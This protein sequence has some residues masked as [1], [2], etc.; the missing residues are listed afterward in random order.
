MSDR[1][2]GDSFRRLI[3]LT[4]PI[5]IQHYMGES[6]ARYY[7]GKDPLGSAGDFVTAPEISQMFGELIGLWLVDIWTRAG[8]PKPVHYVELG[9][10]RGTLAK[11]ALR[12]MRQYG[13]TPEVHFVEGS[14][15][16]RSEQS[17]AVPGAHF[18]DDLS[19]LPDDAPLL[20]VGNEFLDALP[21]RQ[22]VKTAEG[23]RER[24]VAVEGEKFVCVAGPNPMDAAIPVER[25]DAPDGAIIETCP[26]AAAVVG[27]VS[28]RLAAQGGAA[29][30]ID[31]G[32]DQVQTGST[33]QAVR[34]HQKVDPFA[35][36]G[37]ADLTALV[38]F[39][40]LAEMIAP[41]GSRY[42]G[43]VTQGA[44]LKALGIE[45]RAQALAQKSPAHSEAL[46]VA[47]DRLVDDAQMGRL[48]KVMGLA[49]PN[50][51]NGAA[52]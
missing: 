21:I 41:K 22:L 47:K 50:W 24:M 34:A 20:I 35:A 11:D 27:E 37:E 30:L 46:Q 3:S 16:L 48:F 29:L 33:L 40:T 31:Y 23:W 38:D 10:G 15:V 2:L 25:R 5:S 52:F 8:Q 42:L 13:L 12:A 9:P 28:Q 18:H 49:A 39:A 45:Q 7:A 6:N 14:K 36:P 43:T 17:K 4:G 44:W 1:S 51:P 32:Y 19:S 26:G